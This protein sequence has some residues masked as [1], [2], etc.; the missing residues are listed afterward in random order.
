M[1]FVIRDLDTRREQKQKTAALTALMKEF[2]AESVASIM[3]DEKKPDILTTLQTIDV[4][5]AVVKLP[6]H[7]PGAYADYDYRESPLETAYAEEF[8]ANMLAAVGY[9][10]IKRV[11]GMVTRNDP[12]NGP[13]DKWH[14]THSQVPEIMSWRRGFEVKSVPAFKV[15]TG[16]T[17]P[18]LVAGL[19]TRQG[20]DIIA[21][22]FISANAMKMWLHGTSPE[23]KKAFEAL[24]LPLFRHGANTEPTS[25]L[26]RQEGEVRMQYHAAKT[27]TLDPKGKEALRLLGELLND[28]SGWSISKTHVPAGEGTFYLHRNLG[29]HCRT[30]DV[31][32][33]DCLYET[34]GK[35]RATPGLLTAGL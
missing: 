21:D 3:S 19:W 24:S 22:Q 15:K 23:K 25:V 1:V 35:R 18:D 20:G 34:H 14:V 30:G 16:P 12:Y 11:N 32:D 5:T 13:L 31:S 29:V 6:S 17:T 27:T 28:L 26:Y 33:N 8:L 4:F 10:P 7:I 9:D 2:A